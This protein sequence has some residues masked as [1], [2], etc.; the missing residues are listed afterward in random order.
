MNTFIQLDQVSVKFRIYH[1]PSPS[2]KDTAVNLLTGN[3]KLNDFRDFF[4]LHDITLKINPGDRVG[5]IGLNGA[6]KSTLLKTISGI[7]R[8]HQG[9]I[10]INGRITPL[11]ELGAGFDPE[12]TGRKNIYLNG[13][14]LGFSPAEMQEKEREISEFSELDD[15]LDLPVKYYSSGMYGRLA[16]SIAAATEPEI[17][18]ID[19]V[20]ATGDGH[21]V[22][23]SNQR[24]QQMVEKS[25]ILIV[26]SHAIGQIRRLCN[27]VIFLDHGN[28][29]NDGAPDVVIDQYMQ[30][31]AS[32][33]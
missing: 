12:Q 24:I 27:R 21:F 31:I 8:P 11:M 9:K 2:L 16:F 18:M 15:F 10:S 5:L 7:Y 13:A 3:K 1:N 20:F 32:I 26:V 29:I 28:I 30:K 17:L 4:A 23:K 33:K 19:E 14:L 25:S 6:G 22:E